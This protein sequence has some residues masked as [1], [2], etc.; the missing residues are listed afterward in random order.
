MH[1][2][3]EAWCLLGC[4]DLH[5]LGHPLC[6]RTRIRHTL[7]CNMCATLSANHWRVVPGATGNWWY[8]QFT[9]SF[10]HVCRVCPV[11]LFLQ[12]HGHHQGERPKALGGAAPG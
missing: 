4:W 6:L 10:L 5:P 7:P 1:R 12:V 11:I 8:H 2:V 3:R 9:G